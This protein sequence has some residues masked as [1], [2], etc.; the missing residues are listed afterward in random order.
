MVTDPVIQNYLTGNPAD[1]FSILITMDYDPG[2]FPS[3]PN[4]EYGRNWNI[5]R[6]LDFCEEWNYPYTPICDYDTQKISF[7]NQPRRVQ[8]VFIKRDIL[9]IEKIEELDNNINTH[10][11]IDSNL[12]T[13]IDVNET[14]EISP[15]T[16]YDNHGTYQNPSGDNLCFSSGWGRWCYNKDQGTFQ[17]CPT[18]FDSMVYKKRIYFTNPISNR[19]K[20]VP[21]MNQSTIRHHPIVEFDYTDSTAP[22]L[23][24]DDKI[25]DYYNKTLPN[26]RRDKIENMQDKLQ[27]S[28]NE[29]I[30]LEVQVSLNTYLKTHKVDIKLGDTTILNISRDKYII[31]IVKKIIA[32]RDGVSLFVSNSA[33]RFSQ[34]DNFIPSQVFDEIDLMELL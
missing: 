30:N 24:D 20:Y 28:F 16:H 4:G 13:H 17:D 8:Y 33:R 6:F 3:F 32:D 10:A 23:T 34:H 27:D 31:G 11:P 15:N 7:I 29:N 9:K 25:Y 2:N 5:K 12:K 18:T 26:S 21:F 1:W 19:Y 22:D 14:C